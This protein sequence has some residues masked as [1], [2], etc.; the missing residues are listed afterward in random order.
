MYT[1][2]KITRIG[3]H[4]FDYWKAVE[5]LT[6]GNSGY[7]IHWSDDGECITDHVYAEADAYLIAAAPLLLE[8]LKHL[9]AVGGLGLKNHELIRQAIE[10][11]QP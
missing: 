10:I 11:S 3:S 2:S 5:R 7:E 9:D 4:R 6:N 1:K 8:T